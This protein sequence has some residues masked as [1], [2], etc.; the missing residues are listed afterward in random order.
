MIAGHAPFA[1]V[2]VAMH[3]WISDE[4]VAVHRGTQVRKCHTSRRDAFRSV[5]SSPIAYY[6]ITKRT[7]QVS[8]DSCRREANLVIGRLSL[9]SIPTLR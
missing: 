4:R 7:I 2:V 1:E 8:D 3:D 9:S 6:D 5:N